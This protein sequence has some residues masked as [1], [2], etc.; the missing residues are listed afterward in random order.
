[1]AK[2]KIDGVIEAVRYTP[3]GQI[4]W[5]RA[6]ERRGP[7]FSE[8][9]LIDRPGLVS[10][11]KAKKHFVIGRR[12]LQWASTFETSAAVRLIR[13]DG[14]EVIVTDDTTVDHDRLD[15]APLI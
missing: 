14:R 5:V 15:G 4:A 3:Q 9:V 13:L 1:M 11:L 12:I 6:F 8:R 7:T 2:V 10:R